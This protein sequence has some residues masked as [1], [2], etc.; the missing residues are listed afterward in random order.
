MRFL[1][2]QNG[3]KEPSFVIGVGELRSISA[4]WNGSENIHFL[5]DKYMW[6]CNDVCVKSI[7]VCVCVSPNIQ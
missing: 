4:T 6:V 1:H 5:K 7:C 3:L 2:C